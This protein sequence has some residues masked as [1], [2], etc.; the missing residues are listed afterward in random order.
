MSFLS[1]PNPT[2]SQ[3]RKLN[4]DGSVNIHCRQC[5]E[6]VCTVSYRGFSTVD[7]C[8]YC[9]NDLPRPV[10]KDPQE[11]LIRSL[12]NEPVGG[13]QKGEKKSKVPLLDLVLQTFRAIGFRR[14]KTRISEEDAQNIDYEGLQPS[15][16]IVKQKKRE[17]IFGQKKDKK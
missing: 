11:E 9:L 16:Q 7:Y 14:P 17:P 1:D 5:G 2:P 15:E 8:Y 3:N 12:Y 13:L 4:A 6:F 10:N